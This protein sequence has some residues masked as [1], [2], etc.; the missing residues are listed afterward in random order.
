M[1]NAQSRIILYIL[2]RDI[3]LSD[4][5]VFHCAAQQLRR[6]K[7]GKT[8]SQDGR[9]TRDDSLT[10]EH[11]GAPF[12]HFLP[13]YIFP[14]QQI[15]VSGFLASPSDK[16]PYPEAR[17]QVAKVWRTGPHRAKW[18]GQGVW[19]L[20]QQLESL[21]CGTGLEMRVGGVAEVIG[22]ILDS[23]AQ[24][25]G[26][27]NCKPKITGIWM[28]DDDGTEEKDDVKAV[29]KIAAKNDIPFKVWVDEKFYVDEYVVSTFG[30]ITWSSKL[31]TY[32]AVTNH[33]HTFPNC[34]MCIQHIANHWNRCAIDR[35]KYYLHLQN[36]RPYHRTFLLKKPPSKSLPLRMV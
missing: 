22:D 20:K 36:C 18:I 15:E 21:N 28:T 31:L 23:Y 9:R 4:N 12:T 13:V 32:T 24:L 14:P 2:R 27:D 34:Q 7:P 5:P 3:R 6:S 26:N 11:G 8:V 35:G 16:C 30:P 25:A 1:S 33:T 19:D 17:S 29:E 10:S